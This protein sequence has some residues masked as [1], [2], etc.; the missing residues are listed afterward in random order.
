[1][2]IVGNL[3]CQH[4]VIVLLT[5]SSFKDLGFHQLGCMDDLLELLGG[6]GDRVGEIG[7]RTQ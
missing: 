3:V 5:I 4:V 7:A 2:S 1:M 6:V